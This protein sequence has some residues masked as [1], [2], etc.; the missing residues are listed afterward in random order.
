VISKNI[1]KALY[2]TG[3]TIRILGEDYTLILKGRDIVNYENELSTEIN[4][5]KEDENLTFLI[6]NSNN[7]PGLITLKLEYGGYQYLYLYNE[8]KNKYQQL[9]MD[10]LSSI[11]LDITGKY[12][13]TQ[14]KLSDISISIIVIILV[15]VILLGLVIT[16]IA[17][18]KQY[19]FW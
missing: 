18:K 9:K 2:E 14:D 5:E 6:N 12:M 11:S 10:D 3:K 8:T 19:W 16:Y 15:V 17:V 4:I 1:L 13:L 7:L